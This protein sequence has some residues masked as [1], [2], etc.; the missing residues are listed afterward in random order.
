[1]SAAWM[2]LADHAEATEVDIRVNTRRVRGRLVSVSG[3]RR[4]DEDPEASAGAPDPGV[5]RPASAAPQS[6]RL[7]DFYLH[8]VEARRS[9]STD[10]SPA[11]AEPG[12]PRVVFAR[13]DDP[14]LQL[15]RNPHGFELSGRPSEREGRNERRLSVAFDG[16]L[17]AVV[18]QPTDST[19]EILSRLEARLGGSYEMRVHELAPGRWAVG[20]FERLLASA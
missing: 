4:A 16:Q 13:S 19:R 2:E 8:S 17:F 14:E 1:M 9:A 7:S 10:R 11:L 6:G 18:I 20:F 15:R 5:P 12:R 3:A